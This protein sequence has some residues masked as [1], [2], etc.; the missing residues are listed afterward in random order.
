MRHCINN[1]YSFAGFWRLWHATLNKWII[2]YLYRPLRL[3]RS[4]VYS[5]ASSRLFFR[6]SLSSLWFG[7]APRD[8][9]SNVA[10]CAARYLPLGGKSAQIWSMWVIFTFVGLWHDLWCSAVFWVLRRAACD[11][12]C[13]R[14]RWLAWAWINCVCFSIEIVF[15]LWFFSDGKKA[16]GSSLSARLRLSIRSSRYY[17]LIAAAAATCNIM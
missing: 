17:R 16:T 2:R 5:R 10:P 13:C 14:W 3:D 15:G 11:C 12:V 1:N 8:L 4:T 7:V 6:W 9:R